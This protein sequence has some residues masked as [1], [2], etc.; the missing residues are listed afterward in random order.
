[1]P[2]ARGGGGALQIEI[3]KLAMW[4][5]PVEERASREDAEA[6][7]LELPKFQ[8]SLVWSAEQKTKL[9]DSLHK[10]FPVG[11]LL[12]FE[13]TGETPKTYQLVDGLQ[14]TTAIL[15]YLKRPL[16]VFDIERVGG[17]ALDDVVADLNRL[18]EESIAVDTVKRQV[19]AWLRATEVLDMTKFSSARLQRALAAENG[20]EPST[21][22]V[23]E[24]L[25]EHAGNL[26]TSIKDACD[27]GGRTVLADVF[28]GLP[29][30]LPEVFA[31]LNTQGT[32]LKYF[33]RFAAAWIDQEAVVTDGSIQAA[34]KAKYA[35]S[36]AEGFE[37]EGITRARN[38]R[39]IIIEQFSLYEYLFG[40][41]KVL[42]RKHDLLFES[43]KDPAEADVLGFVVTA[44][45]LG[46]K[47]EE[48]GILP[49]RI[50]SVR[51]LA[52]AEPIDLGR[53]REI[54]DDACS[55]VTRILKPYI[56]IKLNKK[57]DNPVRPHPLYQIMS[58]VASVAV[59]KYDM[60][61][62]DMRPDWTSKLLRLENCLPQRY[63]YD[64]I[65]DPWRGAGN[66][67]MFDRVWASTGD[68]LQDYIPGETYLTPVSRNDF[69]TALD[70]W[71]ARQ[72][73]KR[74]TARPNIQNDQR[75]VL[76]FLYAD[77][78]SHF[79][80]HSNHWEIA[81]VVPVS[82]LAR[83]I[84]DSDNHVGW[85]ISAIGNLALFTKKMNREQSGKTLPEYLASVR[86]QD[87]P[88]L[89]TQLGEA[90]FCKIDDA[91]VGPRF[92]LTSYE[93]LLNKTFKKM[94]A[95]LLS[96]LRVA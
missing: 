11:S 85:P 82:R 75:A 3:K 76:A 60:V 71:Q 81:H 32:T 38:G 78:I 87:R 2:V 89:K 65:A 6:P 42:A 22:L 35:K 94:K 74:Q 66:S 20:V 91:A 52:A 51:G 33:D 67:R 80:L 96:K 59:L 79:D 90:L 14:R 10:K 29:E 88:A 12:L 95:E 70:A 54:L 93:S 9:I 40:L 63:L 50:R 19:T 21:F 16:T 83:L 55:E 18:L 39:D 1:M 46:V 34:V 72:M 23:D 48:M 25:E 56:G 26:L 61:S 7:R 64:M 28:E 53:Y 47:Y 44:A 13:K 84:K 92:S 69:S 62:L 30:D 68:G 4:A 77:K 37:I 86:A 58:I 36:L 24:D 73:A 49:A 17:T 8:R 31:R 27:I 15:D 5:T 45:C 43:A 57:D 41:G